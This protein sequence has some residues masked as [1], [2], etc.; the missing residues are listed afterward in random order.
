MQELAQPQ[1]IKF[2]DSQI[3]KKLILVTAFYK[4]GKD[5]FLLLSNDFR[6]SGI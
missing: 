6:K 1:T 5:E 2:S 3:L 4:T